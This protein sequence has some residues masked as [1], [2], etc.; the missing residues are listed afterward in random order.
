MSIRL[1]CPSC[2][3]G[4]VLPALPEHRRATCPRCGDVFPIRTYTEVPDEAAPADTSAP[5]KVVDIRPRWPRRLLIAGAAALLLALVGATWVVYDIGRGM[6]NMDDPPGVARPEPE[7]ATE[8]TALRYLRGN[9]NIVFAIRPEPVIAYAERTKQ[10]PGDVLKRSGLPDGLGG[11][12]EQLGVPLAQVDHLA[13]G[14][15]LGEG[16][17]ALRLTL[18]LVLKQPPADED[19]FLSK[20]KARPVAGKRD[21]YE[22]AVGRFGLLLAR[23]SPTVWAFGLDEKDFTAIETG[24]P[25]PAAAAQFRGD[26]RS[27]L[28]GMIRAVPADAAVWVAADDDRDWTQKPA[29]KLF[30]SAPEVK[31]WL[32]AVKD[33]RGGALSVRLGEQPQVQLRVR[34]VDDATAER[35]RAYFAARAGELP[36]ARSGGEGALA[37]FDS[38][39]NADTGRLLQ[40]FLADASR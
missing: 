31:K 24:E 3:H 14:L 38:P 26:D 5:A 2:N 21:R 32:T 23:V 19:T 40:R 33:G 18:V 13:G 20:L 25:R 28:R 30:G 39:F 8:L 27:G 12:V 16:D 35:V 6:R 15:E 37:E 22:V 11:A 7:T 9:A 36:S 1:S 34:A 17:D 4:F 29:L 10:Q